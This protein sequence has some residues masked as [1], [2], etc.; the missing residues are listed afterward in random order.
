MPRGSKESYSPKQKRMAGHIEDS[1]KRRGGSE[2]D[3]ERIA[4]ATVNKETGGAKRKKAASSRT[5]STRT[6][7]SSRS[8]KTTH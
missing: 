4:W 2:E 3:S 8:K 6:K 7:T 5:A 1:V